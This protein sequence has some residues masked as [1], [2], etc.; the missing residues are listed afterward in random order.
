MLER[1]INKKSGLERCILIGA[2][3]R[4]Q[5]EIKSREYIE[6]LKFLALTAGAKTIETFQ[7]KLDKPDSN[8]FLGSGKMEEIDRFI[9]EKKIDLAIFDDELSPSQ[10]KNIEKLFN[11]KVLDRTNLILDIFAKRRNRDAW[12]WRNSN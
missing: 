1:K 3:T 8:T 7:Q 11:I 4:E 9:K 2:I 6:E 5:D 12:S 10:L